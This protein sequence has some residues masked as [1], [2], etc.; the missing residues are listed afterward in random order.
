[1]FSARDSRKQ[2]RNSLLQSETVNLIEIKTTVYS[3]AFTFFVS[4]VQ[5]QC[6][7]LNI[8]QALSL[9]ISFDSF[10]K[11][12]VYLFL[13][14]KLSVHGTYFNCTPSQSSFPYFVR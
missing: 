5:M 6:P 9:V 8:N 10:F 7:A 13:P 14:L 1:M 12:P 2:K 11:I 3:F 4:P